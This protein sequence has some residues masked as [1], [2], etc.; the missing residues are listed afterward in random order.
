MMMAV[1][2]LRQPMDGASISGVLSRELSR[3]HNRV[4]SWSQFGG[5]F[6][7]RLN[8]MFSR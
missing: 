7:G 4:F 1:T 8:R 3:S 5:S 2:I 6:S